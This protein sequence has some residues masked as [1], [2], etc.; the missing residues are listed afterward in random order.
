MVQLY[1]EDSAG[2]LDRLGE[3]LAPAAAGGAGAGAVDYAALDALAHQLKGSSASFGAAAAAAACARLREAGAAR[4][5]GGCGAAAVALRAG[6][7]ALRARLEEFSALEARRK[8]LAGAGAG[9]GAGR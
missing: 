1:F 6:H 4:D 7:A 3:L 9:A 2:K 5:A 8:A